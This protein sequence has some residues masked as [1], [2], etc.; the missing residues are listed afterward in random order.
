MLGKILVGMLVVAGMFLVYALLSGK[1]ASAA[2]N[3]APSKSTGVGGWTTN[4]G[5]FTVAGVGDKPTSISFAG[6]KFHTGL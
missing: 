1:T 4:R 3:A 2:T 5:G 6:R